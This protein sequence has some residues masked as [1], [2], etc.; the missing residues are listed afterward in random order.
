MSSIYTNVTLLGDT[1]LC[2]GYENGQQISFREV[3][4]PTL[5]V[6]S[7]KGDWKSVDGQKMSPVVQDGARRAREFI[8][9]YK[10]VVRATGDN[11]TA[12]ESM[13]V[14][15]RASD[16]YQL[17][18]YMRMETCR[19]G[20]FLVPFWDADAEG[21]VI[22]EAGALSFRVS[23]MDTG[24][25]HDVFVLAVNMLLSPVSVVTEASEKLAERITN[26]YS[27]T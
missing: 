1:I 21:A 10:D 16:V 24:G 6:P 17:Y 25:K 11:C 7:Q 15:I 9:K 19:V 13:R 4:K 23:P 26:N 18:S 22:S 3:I 12:A 20:F 27:S 2:R 8:A 5:F 14:S